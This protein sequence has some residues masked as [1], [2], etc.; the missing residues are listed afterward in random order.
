[1]AKTRGRSVAALAAAGSLDATA[2][3]RTGLAYAPVGLAVKIA[4]T[5]MAIAATVAVRREV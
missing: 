4:P 5:T 3:A 2:T 1:L